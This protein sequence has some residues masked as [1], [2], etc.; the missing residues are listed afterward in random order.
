MFP[1]SEVLLSQRVT[2]SRDIRIT[3]I[4]FKDQLTTFPGIVRYN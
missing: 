1:V 4:R 3:E 2:A